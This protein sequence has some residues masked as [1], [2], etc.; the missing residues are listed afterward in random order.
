MSENE[1]GGI[2][3][4]SD[5]L[6]RFGSFLEREAQ[7]I[8]AKLIRDRASRQIWENLGPPLKNF[9]SKKE[10]QMWDRS[11]N[12]ILYRIANDLEK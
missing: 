4:N 10:K 2:S 8:A 9:K 3:Q 1:Y 11:I 5:I 6:L 12:G 7:T